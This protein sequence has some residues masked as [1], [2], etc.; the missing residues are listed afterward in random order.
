MDK[1]IYD[2]LDRDIPGLEIVG[3]AVRFGK[4]IQSKLAHVLL[5]KEWNFK[6]ELEQAVEVSARIGAG[7]HRPWKVCRA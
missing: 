6:P 4:S 7:K 2:T 5:W 1:T 3:D